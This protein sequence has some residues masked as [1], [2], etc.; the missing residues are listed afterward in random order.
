[1]SAPF[2]NT[3]FHPTDFSGASEK[4]F[5]HALIISLHRQTSLTILNV[6]DPDDALD[7]FDE[8]PQVR[9]YLENWGYLSPGSDRAE[10]YQKLGVKIKKVN[11]RARSI[12]RAA[13]NYLKD[14]PVDLMV[15]STRAAL[16]GPRVSIAEKLAR[17]S[18]TMT[19]FV[20]DGSD[21]FV[22][23]DSGQVSFRKLMVA[24]DKK[25]NPRAAITY[26]DRAS[27][28]FSQKTGRTEIVVTYVGP[29]SEFP[30]VKIP[31]ESSSSWHQRC[32]EGPVVDSLAEVANQEDVD[33]LIMTTAGHNGILDVFQGS[34]TERVLRKVH[35]PVLAV[36]AH[37]S[38]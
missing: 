12:Y 5:V 30:Q 13:L 29:E 31:V 24:V 17:S 23:K 27:K 28:A 20:P 9:T 35:C 21:G 11:L 19:L 25:P 8:F 32:V 33:L 6:V 7:L 1:M 36:P 3:V 37:I 2:V 15:L 22:N 10:V 14:R 34:V 4:A 18:K 16:E 26:A 38:A